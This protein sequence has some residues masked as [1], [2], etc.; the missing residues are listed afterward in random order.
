VFA[1]GSY[2]VDWV[3]IG[4][5]VFSDLF[6]FYAPVGHIGLA[7]ARE[8]VTILSAL[9]HLARTRDVYSPMQ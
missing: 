9:T 2:V 5:G 6:S 3:N 7:L 1:G 4:A 8:V